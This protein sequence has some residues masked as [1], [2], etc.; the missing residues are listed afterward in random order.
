[1]VGPF[2]MRELCYPLNFFL[3]VFRALAYIICR[4]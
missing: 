3:L 2:F 1:M 4:L